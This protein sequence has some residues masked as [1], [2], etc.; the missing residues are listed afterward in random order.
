M[1]QGT[2][3]V[4]AFVVLGALTTAAVLAHATLWYLAIFS[5]IPCGVSLVGLILGLLSLL[6]LR[7]ARSTA[8]PGFRR[9]GNSLLV[10]GSFLFFQL[11]YVAIAPTLRNWEV[12][13]AQAFI[14]TL[15]PRLEAYR[16][17]YDTY[18]TDMEALVSADTAYPRLLELTG[19]YPRTYDNRQFYFGRTATYGFKF[20]VPDGFIGFYYEYCCGAEGTWTVTD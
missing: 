12:R 4:S 11:A 5:L 7:R 1:K 18:P 17:Q 2:L 19:D 16:A 3:F 14:H 10:V 13:R 9:V 6:L 8:S 20:Y 15:I